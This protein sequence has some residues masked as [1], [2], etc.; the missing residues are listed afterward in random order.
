MLLE[1]IYKLLVRGVP[2][3]LEEAASQYIMKSF[4]I[5]QTRGSRRGLCDLEICDGRLYTSTK[6][7]W[8]DT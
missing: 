1:L 6:N 8:F 2:C 3:E 5:I 7:R 4:G